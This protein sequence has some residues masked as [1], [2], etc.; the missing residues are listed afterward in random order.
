MEVGR[1]E[2]DW[3][4]LRELQMRDGK[5]QERVGQVELK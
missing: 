5:S 4:S 1:N 2:I 3:R